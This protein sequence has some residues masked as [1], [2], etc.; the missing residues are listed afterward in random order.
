MSNFPFLSEREMCLTEISQVVKSESRV[1][2]RSQTVDHTVRHCYTEPLF[3]VWSYFWSQ[4][5]KDYSKHNWNKELFLEAFW[6][7]PEGYSISILWKHKMG[8]G[9]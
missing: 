2:S 9:G 7:V 5:N 6:Y 3:S 4:E 1:D 8:P